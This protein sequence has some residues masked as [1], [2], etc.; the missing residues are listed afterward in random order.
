MQCAMQE[1]EEYAK[2]DPV[3]FAH[4]FGALHFQRIYIHI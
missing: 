2:A 1:V 4:V 3:R